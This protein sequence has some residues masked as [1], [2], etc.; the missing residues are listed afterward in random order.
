MIIFQTRNEK[1]GRLEL[2]FDEIEGHM[3]IDSYDFKNQLVNSET[4]YEEDMK[5]FLQFIKINCDARM[6]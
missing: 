5:K 1:G 3:Y 2:S 6:D 4:I